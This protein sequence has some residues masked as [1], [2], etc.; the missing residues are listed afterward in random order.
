LT[1]Q[2]P[3]AAAIRVP[4]SMQKRRSDW[5]ITDPREMPPEEFRTIRELI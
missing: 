1:P 4:C 3:G 2:S 5:Q